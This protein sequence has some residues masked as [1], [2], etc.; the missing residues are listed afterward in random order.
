MTRNWERVGGSQPIYN[1]NNIRSIGPVAGD[2]EIL[3][4]KDRIGESGVNKRSCL[5]YYL[6]DSPAETY[7]ERS[8]VCESGV[9]KRSRLDYHLQDPPVETYPDRHRVTG[10]FQFQVE[11]PGTG[12]KLFVVCVF[13]FV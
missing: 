12:P 13:V 5:D 11:I 4:M 3:A 9:N 10:K 2:E 8:R 7:P 6:Q 1:P